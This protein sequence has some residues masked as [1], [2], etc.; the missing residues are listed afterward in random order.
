MERGLPVP[1]ITIDVEIWC[2]CGA[3][4]CR[5]STVHPRG[6]GII[7]EPCER[8]LKEAEKKGHEEAQEEASAEG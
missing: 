7:V 1:E 2:S 5:Q 4:L 3:G 6:R 8:C